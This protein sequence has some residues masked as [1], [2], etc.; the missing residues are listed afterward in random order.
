M[1]ETFQ[2]LNEERYHFGPS[3]S[4]YRNHG[5]YIERNQQDKKESLNC[6]NSLT[7]VSSRTTLI[8]QVNSITSRQWGQYAS[9]IFRHLLDKS[10]HEVPLTLG[11]ELTLQLI[12]VELKA[13]ELCGNG[14]LA[15]KPFLLAS[16]E[17]NSF[18]MGLF[19][20]N[21]LII[22]LAEPQ[23]VQFLALKQVDGSLSSSFSHY[24][25]G[26]S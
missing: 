20:L 7:V 1:R 4:M 22:P 19:S 26:R 5:Y 3:M 8:S 2:N 10:L 14:D 11:L 16:S 15:F 25:A 18:I 21:D 23:T 24:P 6:H 17:A 12:P 9:F 13:I